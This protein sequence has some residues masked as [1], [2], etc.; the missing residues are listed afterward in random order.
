MNNDTFIPHILVKAGYTAYKYSIKNGKIEV[1][2]DRL[3]FYSTYGPLKIYFE[4]GESICA[5]GLM[6]VGMP[7][8]LCYPRP[9]IT[10]SN[11]D[12]LI[13][14]NPHSLLN[15]LGLI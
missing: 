3:D 5:Y 14:E 2:Y 1:P 9:T 8:T 13:M 6:E 10:R 15:E 4:K 11:L 7:P 12:R